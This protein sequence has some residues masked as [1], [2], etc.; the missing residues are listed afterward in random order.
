MRLTHN[1]ISFLRLTQLLELVL[2][3]VLINS[4]SLFGHLLKSHLLLQMTMSAN[5]R[6]TTARL[7]MN[8]AIRRD[9]SV[10]S[11]SGQLLLLPQRLPVPQQQQ[12]QPLRDPPSMRRDTHGHGHLLRIGL[13]ILLLPFPRDS[14]ACPVILVSRGVPRELALVSCYRINV[15]LSIND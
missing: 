12:L 11:E 8:A 3:L 5:W 2:F 1:F 15:Q 7:L 9:L 14:K 6:H 13:I 10:V 4:L